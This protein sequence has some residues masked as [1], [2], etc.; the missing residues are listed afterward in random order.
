MTVI[1]GDVVSHA[2]KRWVVV[3]TKPSPKGWPLNCLLRRRR[4]EGGYTTLEVSTDAPE[5]LD[6]PIFTPG[7]EVIIGDGKPGTVVSDDDGPLVRVEATR[8]RETQG[9]Q[10]IVTIGVADVARGGLVVDNCL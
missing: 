4:D 1:V 10:H 5:K 3:E 7:Q 8:R 2:G 6:H 9:G